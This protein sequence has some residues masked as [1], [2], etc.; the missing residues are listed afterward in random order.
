MGKTDTRLELYISKSAPFAQEILWHLTELVHEVCPDAEET[1]KWSFPC[2]MY[3]GSI[4]C[5]I[6]A[7]KKHCA[8]GFWLESKMKDPKK[9]LSRGKAKNGMGSL[10]KLTGIKDLP[11][12]KILKDYI[13]E[14]MKLIEAGE[15]LSKKPDDKEKKTLVIPDY[16]KKALSKNKNALHTFENFSHANKK[17]Y[18]VWITE[19][20]RDETRIKRLETAIEWMAEGKIRNWKYIKKY[21]EKRRLLKI[22]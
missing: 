6:A 20:K 17:E 9:I 3:K 15:K 1:M 2:F 18:I 12:D 4:L 21:N 5:N 16:F 10:G 22:Q 7:F 19:A 14:A 11:S 8:F 13:K